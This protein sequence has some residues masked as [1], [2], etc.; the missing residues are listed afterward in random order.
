[1][2]TT[3]NVTTS[4]NYDPTYS[5]SAIITNIPDANSNF[6]PE[7]FSIEYKRL[8]RN[9]RTTEIG[10]I[11]NRPLT[12]IANDYFSNTTCWWM[13]A[14]MNGFGNPLVTNS[15]LLIALPDIT[16]L[17]EVNSTSAVINLNQTNTTI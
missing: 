4:T 3:L 6:T 9:L 1:M 13:I 12:T 2:S 10:Y 5:R 7:F 14:L 11:T 8:L 15:E 17:T 16:V